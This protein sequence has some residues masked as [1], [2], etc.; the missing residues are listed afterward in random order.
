[1]ANCIPPVTTSVL[2]PD[3]LPSRLRAANWK[4]SVYV[5][6]ALPEGP[7]VGIVGARAASQVGMDRAHAVA[8]HLT[9]RGIHVVSGGALG[10][11]GAAHRGALAAGGTTTV[12][13]A[14]GA[15]LAYP[16][17]HAGLFHQVTTVGGTLVSLWADGT[18]PKPGMFLT[19][20][21]LI[22]ALS[23]AVLVIEADIRS[24][25]LA[26]AAAATKLGRIVGAWPG[27][28]G[29]DSLLDGGAKLVESTE[30]AEACVRGEGREQPIEEV[31]LD[32]VALQVRDAIEAGAC[33]VDA[34]VRQTGIA[35]RA[36]LR[37]LPLIEHSF[38]ARKP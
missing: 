1:M 35:V 7:T 25:S 21:R 19:R 17:R 28:R 15:D 2:T 22:A 13:L 36:V 14:H 9:S 29:C 5:R 37:A 18:Q 24:G 27:S 33:G 38:R 30:D 3:R 10:I 32:P 16:S 11:D 8:R 4:G 12:V 26:T 31:V 6:G 23:D 20:N 34:I